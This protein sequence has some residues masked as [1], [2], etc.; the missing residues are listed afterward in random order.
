MTYRDLDFDGAI[1]YYDRDAERIDETIVSIEDDTA[2][3][4]MRGIYA[5]LNA[6]WVNEEYPDTEWFESDVAELGRAFA[7]HAFR[8]HIR[9]IRN[10]TSN[11]NL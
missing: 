11:R 5:E 10:D 6:D 7:R 8:D 2:R 1:E 3:Q 9:V 4:F